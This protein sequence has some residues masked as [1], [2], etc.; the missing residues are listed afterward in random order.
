M[1]RLTDKWTESK[2]SINILTDKGKTYGDLSRIKRLT[3]IHK[4]RQ[5]G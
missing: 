5:I 4:D 3:Y 1:D 2:T